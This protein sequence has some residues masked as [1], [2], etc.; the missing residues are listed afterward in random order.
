MKKNRSQK[1]LLKKK[2][3]RGIAVSYGFAIGNCA[4]AKN[5]DLSYSKYN[6]P[7]LEVNNEI[8][9]LNKAVSKSIND[10]NLIIKRIKDYKNDIYEEMKFMLEANISIIKSSSLVKDAKKRIESDLINA[11][12]AIIEEMNR[13]SK[14]FKKIKDDYLKDR[15]DDVRDAC[16]RIFRKSW[17]KEKTAKACQKSNFNFKSIKS[18]GPFYHIQ[19]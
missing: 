15:F 16:R 10:L 17:K 4:I 14:I 3:Y 9:R 1:T 19:N 6:I 5:T 18:S 8:L 11:E 12:F 13:H 2:R 7:T